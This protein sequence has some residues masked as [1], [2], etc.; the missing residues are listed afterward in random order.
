MSVVIALATNIAYMK[1]GSAYSNHTS[2]NKRQDIGLTM[3]E[4]TKKTT[5]HEKNVLVYFSAN[6]CMPCTK[7]KPIIDQIETEQKQNMVLLKI[8]VDKNPMVSSYL[9]I[10]TLP[11]F[12]IYKK[13][14]AVWSERRM[15]SKQELTFQIEK[16]AGK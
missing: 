15:L 8:D 5:N 1:K 16:W 7:L 2:A 6:W 12:I 9:E 11:M 14:K 13:G 4:Y 10:N 3:E